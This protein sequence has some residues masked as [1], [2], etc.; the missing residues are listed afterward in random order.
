M[1]EP[2]EQLTLED[3]SIVSLYRAQKWFFREKSLSV[4]RLVIMSSQGQE[5]DCIIF[6]EHGRTIVK[7][8]RNELK[9]CALEL[10]GGINTECSYR[11]EAPAPEWAELLPKIRRRFAPC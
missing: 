3:G 6:E 5:I 7:L 1:P 4:Y 2:A 11:L 8:V 9:F 10:S